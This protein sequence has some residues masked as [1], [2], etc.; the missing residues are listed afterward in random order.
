MWYGVAVFSERAYLT[1]LTGA[2]RQSE[3]LFSVQGKWRNTF[4]CFFSFVFLHNDIKAFCYNPWI[5]FRASQERLALAFHV[6]ELKSKKERR[7]DWGIRPPASHSKPKS[8]M[9]R[10]QQA[11]VRDSR[12]RGYAISCR[13]RLWW[14]GSWLSGTAK[15]LGLFPCKALLGEA[16]LGSWQFSLSTGWLA[17]SDMLNDRVRLRSWSYT[18][19]PHGEHEVGT[20]GWASWSHGRP[21]EKQMLKMQWTVEWIGEEWKGSVVGQKVRW[22]CFGGRKDVNQA[23]CTGSSCLVCGWSGQRWEKSGQR[24]RGWQAFS[25]GWK[26]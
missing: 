25:K 17:V 3:L 19:C 7:R 6:F 1:E 18:T 4:K 23:H 11:D 12:S 5:E 8:W 22:M 21:A 13:D 16:F 14:K 9:L 2:W 10:I 15:G 24:S 20:T 26:I